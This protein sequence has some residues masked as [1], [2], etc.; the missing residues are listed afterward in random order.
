MYDNLF[1]QTFLRLSEYNR[2]HPKSCKTLVTTR[3]LLSEDLLKTLGVEGEAFG[4]WIGNVYIEF[5]PMFKE[6]PAK[7]WQNGE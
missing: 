1:L 7:E 3:A 5:E 6:Q 4:T 2:Q